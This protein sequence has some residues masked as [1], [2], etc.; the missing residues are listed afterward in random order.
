V[1]IFDLDTWQ[2]I[3]STLQRNKLRAALTACGVFWGIFMLIVMLGIGQ[4]LE[5]GSRKQLGGLETRAIFVWS[6]RTSLP[7]KGLQPGRYVK[8]RDADIEALRRIPGVE[9]VAPRLQF[10]GWRQGTNVIYGTK[11]AFFGVMGDN[12]VYPLVEPLSVSRGRFV[13]AMDMRDGRKV[14]VIGRQVASVLFENENPI[15][16]N[17]QVRGVYFQVVGVINSLRGGEEAERLESTVFI[18]FSTFQQAF[19]ERDRVGWFSLTVKPDVPADAL[20]QEIKR[21][22]RARHGIHPDDPEAIGSFNAAEQFGKIQGLFRG[23]R[24]FVWFVGTLTLLAGVLGVSNILLIIVKERT[25][26]I[27]IRKALGAT[28]ASII[29]LVVEESVA[30]TALSGYAGLVAGVATLELIGKAVS[31]VPDAPLAD[32]SVS[33]SA[34]LI[35]TFVL[36]VAGVVAGIVPAR[37]AARV[38]PVEALRAE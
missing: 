18:P 25:K 38:H 9:H 31:K 24:L 13:N 23:I 27:G 35:A 21:V 10:G 28:P 16:K 2:E 29:A 37:L 30:L 34:A 3:W 22:L 33:L 20:E 12:E 32:P 17:L 11:T 36:I 1:G 7:Y 19:N 6:Q 15:G 8:F 4:G 14:A 5:T 26:E